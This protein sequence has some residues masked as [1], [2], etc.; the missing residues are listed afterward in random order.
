MG[1]SQELIFEKDKTGML[2]QLG[3]MIR[4]EYRFTSIF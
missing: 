2:Y 3:Y 1:Q 4:K